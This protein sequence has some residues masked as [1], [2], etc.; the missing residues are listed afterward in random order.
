[1]TRGE[2]EGWMR[3]VEDSETGVDGNGNGNGNSRKEQGWRRR[4]WV[5]NNNKYRIRVAELLLAPRE[6]TTL[7]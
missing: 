5:I 1:M 7:I 2:A 3:D 4:R 6:P